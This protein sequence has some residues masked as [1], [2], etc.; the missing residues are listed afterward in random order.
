MIYLV[1]A[2][3]A[4]IL[5]GFSQLLLKIGTRY[6]KTPLSIYVNPSSIAGYCLF[7]VVTICSVLA[8]KGLDLK[9][10]YALTSLNYGV[11][12]AF[13]RIFL[14]ESL[15]RKKIVA[16]FIIVLGIVMFNSGF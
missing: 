5:T 7:L 6:N 3:A 10:L 12:V 9:L 4:I 8:L 11:T 1:F 2:F 15:D 13:S 16:V 14:H